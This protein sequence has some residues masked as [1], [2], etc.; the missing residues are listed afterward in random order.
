M[1]KSK[2]KRVLFFWVDKLQIDRRERVSLAIT[3][4]VLV[5]L[6]VADIF[7]NSGEVSAP[8]NHEQ[9]QKEFERRS[10]IAKQKK[11][12]IEQRYYPSPVSH[13]STEEETGQVRV[14][15]VIGQ[16]SINSGTREELQ[17]L[18]GIGETYAKRII[19]YR[20]TNGG[21]TSVDELTK[22]KGIGEKTLEKLRAFVKL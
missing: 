5:V 21:F 4:S 17:E 11:E 9:I 18:P 14:P 16:I 13:R 22:V 15:E 7:I 20:E 1:G 8:E 2:L 10:A 19:E 3:M 12:E 6:L